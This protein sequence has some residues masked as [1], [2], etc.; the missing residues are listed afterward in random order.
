VT[1]QGKSEDIP[2]DELNNRIR[3]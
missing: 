3:E 2:T 1:R